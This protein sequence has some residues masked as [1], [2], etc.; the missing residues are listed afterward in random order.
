M[1]NWLFNPFVYIAGTKAFIIGWAIILVTA[2][3]AFFTHT[4]FDG[5]IDIHFGR[6]TPWI[7][8]I[9]EPLVDWTFLVICLYILGRIASESSVRFIDFAG[10][11]AL[12]RWPM[13]LATFLGFIP[14][15]H[16]DPKTS[17]KD[18]EITAM[19]PSV[20]IL[21]VLTIPLIVWLVALLYNAFSVSANLKGRKAAWTFIAGLVMAEI[22]SKIILM[23][24]SF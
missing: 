11:L 19:T 3:L 10:T 22:V 15:P 20:I 1:K 4:H 9:I 23:N 13:L 6:P 24:I 12:A 8:C 14:V 5:A 16:I 7:N 18:I 21:G 17:L 2:V